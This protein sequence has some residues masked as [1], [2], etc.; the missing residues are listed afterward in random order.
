MMPSNVDTWASET[1]SV[2]LM[3]IT[4]EQATCLEQTIINSESAAWT[5]KVVPDA[6]SF[7]LAGVI[8]FYLL[9]NNERFQFPSYR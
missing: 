8:F 4:S 2:L 1:K 6:L 9:Q 7:L 5:L 3:R